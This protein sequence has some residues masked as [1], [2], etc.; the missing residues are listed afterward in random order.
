MKQL[1]TLLVNSRY[2]PVAKREVRVEE[3]YLLEGTASC[4]I[5]IRLLSWRC[6]Y[7]DLCPEKASCPLPLE[8]ASTGEKTMFD[9]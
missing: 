5:D 9:R 7:E 6:L 2:C 4:Q 1:Q 3:I 8:Y